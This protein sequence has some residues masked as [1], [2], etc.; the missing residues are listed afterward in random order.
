MITHELAICTRGRARDL[1]TCLESV[2]AQTLL[3]ERV[4]IVDGSDDGETA[5]LVDELRRSFPVP[6]VLV[7]TGPGIGAARNLAIAV[8]RRDVVHFVDD[9][10][11]LETGYLAGIIGCLGSDARIGAVGG[12]ITDL[13]YSPPT[14]VA[15][16]LGLD[17]LAP[18]RMLASGHVSLVGDVARE[19]D[20]DW[21]SGCAMSLRRGAI[22]SGGCDERFTSTSDGEDVDLTWRIAQHWRVVVTPRARLEHHL[23]PVGRLDR[24]RR[25]RRVV[26]GRYLRVRKRT[27]RN[28]PVAFWIAVVGQ[29][30]YLA[31][32][33]LGHRSRANGV[34]AAATV[35]GVY[36]ALRARPGP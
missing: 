14:R 20:A 9:D 13:S 25:A 2:R 8:T 6:I 10:T 35:L 17:S 11:V 12:V 29:I 3:P 32:L 4:V 26:F 28:R 33:G 24:R 15:R 1:R 31:V 23:S 22:P 5:A 21:L 34:L 16:L 27:G 7:A 30:A 36:D 19:L 18:G